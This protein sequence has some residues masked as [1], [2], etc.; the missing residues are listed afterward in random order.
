TLRDSNGDPINDAQVNL[1]GDMN[2][3]G[4]QPVLRDS[5]VG[6]EGDYTVPF[7]WTMGGDWFVVVTA[8]LPDGLTVEEEFDFT[9]AGDPMMGDMDMATEDMDDMDMAATEE[10]AGS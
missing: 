3:A 8:E 10:A 6:R 7:E 1:R 4:M 5:S 9:V 2:H